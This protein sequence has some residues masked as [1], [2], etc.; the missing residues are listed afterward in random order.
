MDQNRMENL[1]VRIAEAMNDE[2]FC[3]AML[4]CAD[5]ESVCRLL[6]E[7]GI[8]ATAEEITAFKLEGDANL[9][10]VKDTADNELS[11]EELDSVAGGSKFWR[12]VGA[13]AGGAVLGFGLGC[14]CG[15][16]PAFTPAAYKIA[17]G[18]AVVA[19]VWVSRG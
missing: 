8:E 2:K 15:L 11:A 19:G 13:L 6:A 1:Q 14:V 10:K 9:Q 4:M 7:N 16:A 3:A 17:T 5:A 12:G 18:Y